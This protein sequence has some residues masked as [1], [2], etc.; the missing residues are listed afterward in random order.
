M[1]FEFGQCVRKIRDLQIETKRMP[2]QEG[3]NDKQI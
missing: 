3:H 1:Y 2:K